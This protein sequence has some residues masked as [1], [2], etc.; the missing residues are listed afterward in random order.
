MHK[1]LCADAPA[2]N[3]AHRGAHKTDVPGTQMLVQALTGCAW[4]RVFGVT[5]PVKDLLKD[6][7]HRMEEARRRDHR[8]VG[9]QM[10]LFFFDRLSPGSCFFLPNGARVYNTL[11]EARAS[12]KTHLRKR[13]WR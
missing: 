9:T 12:R 7:Q 2:R 5:F 13:W 1:T 4:Q 3:S 6:Y 8:N 11:V 10:E